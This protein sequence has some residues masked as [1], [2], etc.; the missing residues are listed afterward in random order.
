M[1]HINRSFLGQ[2]LILLFLVLFAMETL[3]ALVV[4]GTNG[5]RRAAE[6]VLGVESLCAGLAL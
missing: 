6:K 5:S 1:G 4:I 3:V 2:T